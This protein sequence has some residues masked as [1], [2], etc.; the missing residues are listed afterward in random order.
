MLLGAM[1]DAGVP[2]ELFERTV[3]TLNVGATLERSHVDRSGISATKIDV[4]V[5]GKKDMPRDELWKEQREQAHDP[6]QHSP[7]TRKHGRHLSSLRK[8]IDSAP[9]SATAKHTATAI[10]TAL[11]GAEAKVH[12]TDIDEVHFHEVGAADAIVDIVCAAVGV[13]ALAVDR[14]VASPLNVGGGTVTCD[15]GV[16]PVPAPATLQLLKGVP[17]YCGEIQKELV[18]PTGA[19]IVR[20]LSATFGVQP[21][22]TIEKIGYG[23]G[24]RNFS[25]H[26]NVLRLVIGE[27]AGTHLAEEQ[28]LEEDII[29]LEANLDDLSP[30]VIGYAV[31]RLLSLGALDVFTTAAQMKKSRPGTLLTVLAKPQDEACLRGILLEETSTLG[32]RSRRERRHVLA[33]RHEAVQTPWGAVRIK[34]GS[35]GLA[36]RNAAPEFEDCRRIAEAHGLPLKAVM[37]EALRLYLDKT[38]G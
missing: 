17:I 10:F 32:V 31:E 15:H 19:A 34:I 4:L 24:F 16:L 36:E 25:G 18:T 37:Q 29:V 6:A 23:A 38:N 2:F 9:I 3:A 27:A 12:N 22:M 5:D 26:A 1:V 28:L 35:A 11:A 13:E 21:E 7:A 20:V 8:I 33:R 14:I 30:Q